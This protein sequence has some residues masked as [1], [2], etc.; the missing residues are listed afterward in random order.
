MD[1]YCN[2]STKSET[3]WL[4]EPQWKLHKQIAHLL[5]SDGRQKAGLRLLCTGFTS[6][7]TTQSLLVINHKFR[8][9]GKYRSDLTGKP[10]DPIHIESVSVVAN[11]TGVGCN[12]GRILQ[13]RMCFTGRELC[14]EQN[15]SL[16]FL[17]RCFWESKREL[18]SHCFVTA[19]WPLVDTAGVGCQDLSTHMP[20]NASFTLIGRLD[21]LSQSWERFKTFQLPIPALTAPIISSLISGHHI[22]PNFFLK[23]LK[24]SFGNQWMMSVCAHSTVTHFLH[25]LLSMETLT[26]IGCCQCTRDCP[27][28]VTFILPVFTKSLWT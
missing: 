14:P 1:N 15:K 9:K 8:N 20:M 3:C 24:Q 12:R 27:L 21:R 10:E 25:N 2:D 22:T 4:L 11:G 26:S 6:R 28:W 13:D 5:W 7:R 18:I 16:L 23:A 19:D 17:R